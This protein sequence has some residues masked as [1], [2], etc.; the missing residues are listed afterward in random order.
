MK[1]S[2]QLALLAS[3]SFP[4]RPA[5]VMTLSSQPV[6]SLARRMFWPP[7]P[8]ACD[9]LSSATAISML[10]DSSSTTMELDFRRRH[11]VDDELRRVLVARDD[12]DALAGDLV[13]TACTREPRM[14]TQAPTGSMRG[15]LLFTAILART[16]GSRA[17]PRM[18][19]RPW[20]TSGHFELEQ[21]DQEFAA[22]CGQEQLRAAR[23][24]AHVLA[25]R[26]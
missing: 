18:L 19:I 4:R 23:L 3:R 26:P 13:R 8:M 17:A 24:G 9:S 2:T 14:P 16:P 11:R 10:C 22:P 6:S 1:S 20:P 25:G 15:S 5:R 21:L 12:V 7:R